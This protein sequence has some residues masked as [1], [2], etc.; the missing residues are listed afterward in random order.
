VLALYA[1][2]RIVSGSSM[3]RALKASWTGVI[4]ARDMLRCILWVVVLG[5]L[6]LNGVIF[7]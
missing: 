6:K 5:T 1:W 3:E 4:G 7:G 2:E